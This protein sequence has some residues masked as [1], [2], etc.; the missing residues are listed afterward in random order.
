MRLICPNCGA[1]YE[2]PDEVIPETGRDVQCSNCGDTWFQNHPDHPEPEPESTPAPQSSQ[3]SWDSPEETAA[4]ADDQTEQDAEPA[5]EPEREDVSEAEPDT[6]EA[7]PEEDGEDTSQGGE[8]HPERSRRQ[9]DPAIADVLREEAEHEREARAAENAGSLET[10]PDLGLTQDH[11]DDDDR[12]AREVRARMS[13]L[14]GEDND[15]KAPDST[16]EAQDIDPSSR[17]NLLPDIDEINSSLDAGAP[18]PTQDTSEL[19]EMRHR[20]TLPRKRS[21]FKRGFS[22][23]IVLAALL[24]ALYVFAPRIAEMVPALSGPLETYVEQINALRV[25]VD[26]QFGGV[27]DWLRDMSSPATPGE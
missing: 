24:L 19:D 4:E 5:S 27:R 3:I 9:L 20:D 21:G 8:D 22:F 25:L 18:A 6:V 2:V 23:A 10:Q 7:P 17:R 14:R 1:Q 26:D 12:R 15:S 16:P 11:D 13:R